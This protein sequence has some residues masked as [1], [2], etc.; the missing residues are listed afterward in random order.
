MGIG[1]ASTKKEAQTEAAWNF[2][3]FLVKENELKEN[4]LPPKQ[5]VT[6]FISATFLIQLFLFL[7]Y[8]NISYTKMNCFIF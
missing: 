3:D 2:V 8:F 5:K 6:S 1:E 7:L 4:E